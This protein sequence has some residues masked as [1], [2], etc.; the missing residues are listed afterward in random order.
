M[1]DLTWP[2][3]VD[4]SGRTA[5]VTGA[6]EGIGAATVHA[7]AAHG[8]NVA[9]C[10]RGTSS[11]TALAT[12]LAHLPGRVRGYVADLADANATDRFLDAVSSDL[13]EADILVNNVGNSPSRNFLHM[14]DA[15]WTSLFELN[16]M[17]AVR[18]TRRLLPAMRKRKWGRV[19]MVATS[20]AKYP[21]PALIDYAAS[22]AAMV[23][24]AS[25][26]AKKYAADGVLINSVLPGLI[27]TPMWERTA[28]EV[29][30][31]T[32]TTPDAVFA[33]RSANVPV[34]RYGSA[35]E[36]AALILFLASPYAGYING[37]AID[38]DGGLGAA[39]Y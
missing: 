17:S 10:A 21:N 1:T 4:L 37:A 31:A 6:S 25:A 29:A 34:R 20:G 13:G 15:D 23:A 7:L 32:G 18:C 19:V 12:Q 39:M 26:L 30:Q 3:T 36:V 35:A 2:M 14:T 33:Q 38:V 16:L 9:F 27:R 22:K 24:T 28:V 8:A 5:V 11:G